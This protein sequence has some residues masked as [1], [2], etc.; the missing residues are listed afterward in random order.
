MKTFTRLTHRHTPWLSPRLAAV[1]VVLTLAVSGIGLAQPA[2]ALTMNARAAS[3]TSPSKIDP[4]D[5]DPGL[6][7]SDYDFYNPYAMT[8]AD[9]QAFL[10]GQNCRPKDGSLCLTD[11]RQTTTT[12]P[13]QGDGHCAAYRGARHESASRIIAKVA[14]ACTI[15]PRVLLVLLQKEQSLLT[16]PSASGYLRATGYGCPDTADC[17]TTYFGFF[18]QLYN[19]AWQFRQYT[20]HPD[21]AYAIGTVTVGFHPNATCGSA[22]VTIRNQATANLY[23]YTPYQPNAAV[24][25]SAGSDGDGCSTFGNLNFWTFYTAWFG[26]S[27]EGP[28]PAFFD[29]CLNLTGGQPCRAPSLLPSPLPSP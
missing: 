22:P 14:A 5:F 23:N 21:R 4:A 26:P 13:A 27:V 9:I 28:F 2:S 24:L 1:A 8:Q 17:D 11:Y 6:I 3:P 25:A 12:Q 18:N 15:S 19:A 7:I 29:D 16:R 10:R 20:E